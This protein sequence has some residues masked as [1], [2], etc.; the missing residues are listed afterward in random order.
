MGFWARFERARPP[1]SNGGCF[2]AGTLVW[3]D[4][5][6]IPIEQIKVGDYVLSK[7][8]SG[9]GELSYQKVTKTFAHENQPILCV[10]VYPE[11]L[12]IEAEAEKKLIDTS[13]YLTLLVTPNHPFWVEGKGWVE[14]K[15]LHVAEDWLRL[16]DGTVAFLSDVHTVIRMDK[17]DFG[18]LIDGVFCPIRFTEVD[19]Y[20][21]DLSDNQIKPHLKFAEKIENDTIEW[22]DRN[23][24]DR[25]L[26]TVYNIEVEDTHTYFVGTEGV[27]VHN[28]G[29]KGP[30]EKGKRGQARINGQARL[31][32]LHNREHLTATRLLRIQ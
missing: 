29:E 20:W 2:V 17:P 18:W 28:K 30:R 5:G 19:S 31:S 27:W 25:L 13:Q 24:E 14:A 1:I 32:H 26:R 11:R 9:E 21:V 6:H 7:P 22:W 12:R 10:V 23:P 3:T 4:K 15:K 8:E 16:S